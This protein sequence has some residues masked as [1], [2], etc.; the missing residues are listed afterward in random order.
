MDIQRIGIEM[1]GLFNCAQA[2]FNNRNLGEYRVS[3]GEQTIP[4]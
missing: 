3:F 2:I 4:P 1:R